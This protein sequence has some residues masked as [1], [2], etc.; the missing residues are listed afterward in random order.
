MLNTTI[1]DDGEKFVNYN[2]ISWTLKNAAEANILFQ[3]K[4]TNKESLY[5]MLL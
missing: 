1:N 4:V 3:R 2:G 5:H